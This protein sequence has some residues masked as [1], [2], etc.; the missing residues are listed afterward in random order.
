MMSVLRYFVIT[1][2]RC[3]EISMLGSYSLLNKS[4]MPPMLPKRFVAS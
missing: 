1:L 2:F 3:F 4:L